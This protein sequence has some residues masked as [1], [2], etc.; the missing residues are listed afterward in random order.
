MESLGDVAV[1]LVVADDESNVS[2]DVTGSPT[3]E[4]VNEAVSWLG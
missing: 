1:V 3:S 2:F 4:E